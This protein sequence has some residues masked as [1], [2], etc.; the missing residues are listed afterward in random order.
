[1]RR[2]ADTALNLEENTNIIEE[3]RTERND[4]N[5]L[6]AKRKSTFPSN[7]RHATHT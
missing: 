1:M 5:R 6:I 2:Y 4:N 7:E 3:V